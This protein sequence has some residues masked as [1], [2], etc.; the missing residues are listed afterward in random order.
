MERD[1]NDSPN[2]NQEQDRYVDE[3]TREKIRKHMSDPED[4]ITDEDIANV[5][6]DMYKRSEDVLD[7]E[8]LKKETKPRDEIAPKPPNTWD[9]LED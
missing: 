4:R 2:D 7:E 8:E 3:R 5:N 6:T 1:R 9:I